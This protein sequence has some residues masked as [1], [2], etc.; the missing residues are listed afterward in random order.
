MDREMIGLLVLFAKNSGTRTKEK[1]FA[2]SSHIWSRTGMLYILKETNTVIIFSHV[3]IGMF[4][5]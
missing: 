1:K 5:R 3:G 2:V 4:S